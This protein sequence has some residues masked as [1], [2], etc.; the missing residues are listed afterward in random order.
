MFFRTPHVPQ[1]WESGLWF[2]ESTSTLLAG[3]LFTHTGRCAAL[4][5]SD[6]IATALDADE[7]FHATCLTT[8]RAPT[9]EQLAQ[10]E[11][12]TLALM[13]GASFT[14]DGAGQLRALAD[15]Y[16]AMAD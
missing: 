5:E 7:L 9:P 6:C 11:P 1:N 15:G 4:T 2:D 12:T 16:A 3:D 8:N 10:F 13:H 14:G